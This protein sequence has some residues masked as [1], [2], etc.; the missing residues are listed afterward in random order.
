VPP[1]FASQF[2]EDLAKGLAGESAIQFEENQMAKSPDKWAIDSP[3][4][5]S[6]DEYSQKFAHL[7]IFHLEA[8]L[9][10]MATIIS[11]VDGLQRTAVQQ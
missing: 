6:Q 1:D 7:P 3:A 8:R 9:N 5:F 4:E 10:N 2:K 11:A